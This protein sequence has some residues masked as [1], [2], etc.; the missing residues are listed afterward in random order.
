M[1]PVIFQVDLLFLTWETM[2]INSKHVLDDLYQN[3]MFIWMLIRCVGSCFR[4]VRNSTN[5][6]NVKQIYQLDTPNYFLYQINLAW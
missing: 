4:P 1:T 6:Y 5:S 2:R 3:K